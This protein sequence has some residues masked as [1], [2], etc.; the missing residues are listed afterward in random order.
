MQNANK[1][2]NCEKEWGLLSLMVSITDE[3]VTTVVLVS[4][5][6]TME[7]TARI[8]YSKHDRFFVHF[9]CFKIQNLS[10]VGTQIAE[11]QVVIPK[12]SCNPISTNWYSKHYQPK[13]INIIFKFHKREDENNLLVLL[14]SF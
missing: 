10:R 5:F 12:I 4:D 7:E 3:L 6:K 14:K 9:F 11:S 13:L 2:T 8:I 1:R